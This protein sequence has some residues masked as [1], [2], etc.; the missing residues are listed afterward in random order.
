MFIFGI[1]V[2]CFHRKNREH[3][4]CTENRR[5]VSLAVNWCGR[6]FDCVSLGS[7]ADRCQYEADSEQS[8]KVSEKQ[9]E[10]EI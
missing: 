8:F 4:D 7:S 2:L 1:Y 5:I 9:K 6:V 10:D 3:K